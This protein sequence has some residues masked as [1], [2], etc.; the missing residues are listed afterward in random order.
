VQLTSDESW[1]TELMN[2]RSESNILTRLMLYSLAR[3]RETLYEKVKAQHN[4][5]W[6]VTIHDI[7]NKYL[8]WMPLLLNS[9]YGAMK[10]TL[11]L[12]RFLAIFSASRHIKCRLYYRHIHAYSFRTVQKQKIYDVD[13]RLRW[14]WRQG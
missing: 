7:T 8:E 9:D 5:N 3:Q 12:N 11:K 6:I 2:S 1:N 14:H 4:C 10:K 13:L